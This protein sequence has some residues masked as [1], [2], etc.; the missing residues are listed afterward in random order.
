MRTWS[1]HKGILYFYK[2]C[3]KC[4][5]ELENRGWTL[6]DGSKTTYYCPKHFGFIYARYWGV[7]ISGEISEEDN[8]WIDYF[9]PSRWFEERKTRLAELHIGGAK[10]SF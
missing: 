2:K 9:S 1:F 3:I 6:N 10:S 5:D 8:Y 7:K 4:G